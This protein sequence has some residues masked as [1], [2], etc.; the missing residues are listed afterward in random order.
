MTGNT[1]AA[2]GHAPDFGRLER[3]W[4]DAVIQQD[5]TMLERLLAADYVLVVSAAP[6]RAVPR[7]TW[8]D[9]ALGPYRVRSAQ[10]DGLAVRQVAADV[11]T[12]SLL[13][14]LEASVGGVDRSTTHF[15]FSAGTTSTAATRTPLSAGS[16]VGSKL[17]ATKSTWRR[18]TGSPERGKP[19]HSCGSTYRQYL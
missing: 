10:I 11:A 15:I 5:R 4:V 17:S 6:D 9:Q 16:S 18:S 14:T 13:L 8:L 2:T 7:A 3:E 19:R 1:S 12:V